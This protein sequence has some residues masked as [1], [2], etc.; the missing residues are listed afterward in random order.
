[1]RRFD[2][3]ALCL[4]R[5]REP[6]A[7]HEGHLF[8]KEC[9]YTDLCE[10]LSALSSSVLQRYLCF[11]ISTVSQKQAIKKQK[12]KL[13]ALKREAED[14]RTRA[15]NAA[16]ERVL[17]DFEKGQLALGNSGVGSGLRIDAKETVKSPGSAEEESKSRQ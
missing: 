13:E 12:T 14:E 15:R 3:C 5:A 2:A 4:N 8:C 7:C 9:V 6:L 11:R 10:Y 17:Q 16:R 1:M